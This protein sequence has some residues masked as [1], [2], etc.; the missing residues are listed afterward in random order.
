MGKHDRL[1]TFGVTEI[2]EAEYEKKLAYVLKNCKC[3]SCPTFV[4]GD[5]HAGFCFPLIGTSAKIQKEK[6]CVCGTCAIY[7]EYELNHTYYCTRCSQVCQMNKAEGAA[8]HG[9]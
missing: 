7:K 3:K 6:D 5:A 8:A 9:N 4:P 2:N 1:D